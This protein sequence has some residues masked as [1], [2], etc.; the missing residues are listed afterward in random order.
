[1]YERNQREGH[2]ALRLPEPCAYVWNALAER[3]NGIMD[4]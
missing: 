1:M 2:Y 4:M 3:P